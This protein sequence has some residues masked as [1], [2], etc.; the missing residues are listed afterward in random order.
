MSTI[1]L[2]ISFILFKIESYVS[3]SVDAIF[4]ESLGFIIPEIVSTLNLDLLEC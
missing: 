2:S 4:E 3:N 1:Y